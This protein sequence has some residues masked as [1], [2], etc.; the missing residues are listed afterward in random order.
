MRKTLLLLHQD[1]AVQWV[2]LSTCDYNY[3]LYV[4]PFSLSPIKYNKGISDALHADMRKADTGYG[5][6]HMAPKWSWRHDFHLQLG[7]T[8]LRY[9][10]VL[11][12]YRT[13]QVPG[14][15]S[16]PISQFATVVCDGGKRQTTRDQFEFWIYLSSV[17]ISCSNSNN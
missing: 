7:N 14:L 16:V 12:L 11:N 8:L 4:P 2:D 15:L 6:R 3:Y 10:T 1:A 5:I 9:C 13:V 17:S